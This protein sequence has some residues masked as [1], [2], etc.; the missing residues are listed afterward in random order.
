MGQRR[1]PTTYD[2][3]KL[4]FPGQKI[5]LK[6]LNDDTEVNFTICKLS[7]PVTKSVVVLAKPDSG[8]PEQVVI[9]IYDPRYLDERFIESGCY[10]WNLATE[11][12]A[13]IERTK[14]PDLSDK[15]L[16]HKMHS[17]R[18]K[19][20]SGED[21]A[22]HDLSWEENFYRTMMEQYEAELTAYERLKDLQ[23]SAIPRL[24]MAGQFL[25]SDERAIRPPAL[26]LEYIPSVNLYDVP[27]DAITPA[28]REQVLSAIESFP[29]YGVLH[30]DIN[31]TNIHLT[32][33]EKPVK[34]FLLD[35]GSARIRQESDREK[36]W[37]MCG[38]CDVELATYLLEDKYTDR[39]SPFYAQCVSRF[40]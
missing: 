17:H 38:A 11:Q 37:T 22:T 21:R 30:N 3:R 18:R 8:D 14:N 36:T 29:L 7:T 40:K 32:P 6:P 23:G 15:E 10:K 24:I 28:I 25:P 33:P 20:L 19:D 31:L 9:K 4:F 34:G 2:A 12:T 27:C 26:V 1:F 13:A 39:D 35:F 5:S 16:T